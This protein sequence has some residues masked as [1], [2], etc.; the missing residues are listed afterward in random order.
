MCSVV[1]ADLLGPEEG[2]FQGSALWWCIPQGV[3]VPGLAPV[4]G[5]STEA[6]GREEGA[7][8]GC[9]TS[10]APARKC[11]LVPDCGPWFPGPHAHASGPRSRQAM[12][13]Q[14]TQITV[15]WSGCASFSG[16]RVSGQSRPWGMKG[17]MG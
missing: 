15:G 10:P 14:C 9:S 12:D 17:K 1:W 5:P 7:R 6:Q 4:A 3:E 2:S 11:L 13:R 16:P 8:M